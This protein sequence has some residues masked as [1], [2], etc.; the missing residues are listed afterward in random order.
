MR[1]TLAQALRVASIPIG[2]GVGFWT[3][4]LWTAPSCP[5]GYHCPALVGTLEFTRW[6]CALFGAG[7]A[8]LLVLISFVVRCA[9][10]S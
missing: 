10:S 5:P 8:A 6:Q 9:A 2:V 1:W 4:Q 7:A 3:A